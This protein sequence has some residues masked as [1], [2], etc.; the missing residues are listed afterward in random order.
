MEMPEVR[1]I[2]SACKYI[3]LVKSKV[4]LLMDRSLINHSCKVGHHPLAS[5]NVGTKFHGDLLNRFG[6]M[7]LWT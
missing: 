7:P 3:R 4:I 5:V 2:V 6:D 1:K